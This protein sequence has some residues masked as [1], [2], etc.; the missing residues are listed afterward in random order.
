[1]MRYV[2]TLELLPLR[3]A[4]QSCTL[5][6]EWDTK[7]TFCLGS[8]NQNSTLEYVSKMGI[9]MFCRI[10]SDFIGGFPDFISYFCSRN[11]FLSA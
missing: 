4:I 9:F 3:Y 2:F 10:K 11:S 8:I 1:M 7:I 5:L 6:S